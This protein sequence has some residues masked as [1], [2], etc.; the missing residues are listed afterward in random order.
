MLSVW[1]DLLEARATTRD[2]HFLLEKPPFLASVTMHQIPAVVLW[3][4]LLWGVYPIAD[5]TN[6]NSVMFQVSTDAR[7]KK[8]EAR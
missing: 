3:G 5:F 6:R 8:E 1:C 4:V 2:L 7:A